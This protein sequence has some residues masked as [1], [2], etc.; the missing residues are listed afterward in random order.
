MNRVVAAALL[1]AFSLSSL[2][3][4]QKQGAPDDIATLS[5]EIANVEDAMRTAYRA[6]D[7]EKL[8][9]LYAQDATLYVP[10]EL[11]PRVGSATILEGAKKDFADP[12]FNVN[13]TTGKIVVDKSGQ[14]GY[15]KGSFTIRYTD[16]KT[17]AASGYSGYYLTLFVRQADGRWKVIEDMA[18]PAS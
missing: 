1:G 13:F 4:C 8:A 9:A 11:R 18:V 12:A 17:Q 7:P 16:P 3:G 5:G 15:S 10:G 14:S 6:K 2:T